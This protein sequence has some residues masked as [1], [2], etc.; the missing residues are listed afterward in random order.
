[1]QQFENLD[2]NGVYVDIISSRKDDDDFNIML[3]IT[4]KR[5]T[6]VNTSLEGSR[7][8]S[9]EKGIQELKRTSP[10]KMCYNSLGIDFLP[11]SFL[12]VEMEF[13]IDDILDED[14]FEL[15]LSKLGKFLLIRKN[16]TW[17]VDDER[18]IAKQEKELDTMLEHFEALEEK[19]G[20]SIQNMS[21]KLVSEDEIKLYCEVI[22]PNGEPPLSS[23]SIEVAIYNKSNKIIGFSS[24]RRDKDDFIGY[25]VF[26]FG[27]HRG[28][29]SEISKIRFYPTKI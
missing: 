4:N 10:S 24:I 27:Q 26:S 23:F 14:R 3:R 29:V 28:D 7:Y 25:E 17:F 19:I 21:A 12:D 22:S 16:G 13:K 18:T 1:M 9:I 20:I 15:Q 2:I 8:I 11:N 6:N 5:D